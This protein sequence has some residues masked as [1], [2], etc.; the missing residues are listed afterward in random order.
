MKA[1]K[2]PVFKGNFGG[3][4]KPDDNTK[5]IKRV[6]E[7]EILILDLTK[8]LNKKNESDKVK[9]RKISDL[10]TSVNISREILNEIWV[11]LNSGNERIT[12]ESYRKLEELCS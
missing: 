11:D 9:T 8:E 4:D 3:Q 7:Q 2:A 10:E 12:R 6:T 1:E 5:L